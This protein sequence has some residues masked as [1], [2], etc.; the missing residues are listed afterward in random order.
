MESDLRKIPSVDRLLHNP[1]IERRFAGY[2]H[3]MLVDALRWALQHVREHI[4][5]GSEFSLD[6][7]LKLVAARVSELQSRSLI[8]VINATGVVLHTNL[9]RAPLATQAMESIA[10]VGVGYNNLEISLETGL[11]G[12]RVVH[13]RDLLCDLT[14]AEEAL[15]VNNNAAAVLLAL[16]TL[17]RGKEVIVSRG[18]LIEIGGS[19]RLPD[20]L[21]RSGA[22]LVEVGTTNRTYLR[23]YEAAVTDETALFLKSHTS[24]YRITGFSFRPDVKDLVELGQKCSV[25]VMEDLGSGLM[26]DLSPWGLPEEPVIRQVVESGV[27]LVSFSGDKLL[28][29]PQAGIVVGRTELVSKMAA[30]PLARALRV[31]KLTL[32]ALEP[33]LRVYRWSEHPEQEI[34]HLRMMV[35]PIQSVRRRANRLARRLR[36]L[37]GLPYEVSV[38]SEMA[39]VG[40]GSLPGAQIPTVALA[41]RSDTMSMDQLA[42]WLRN[43]SPPILGRIVEDR[44]IL[45][46][47]T[48]RNEE[49]GLI[50]ESIHQR[51]G[52]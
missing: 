44:V 51:L 47:R 45:D 30:N 13:V 17:A 31:D 9:G 3:P 34:P 19:F 11:R 35:E 50:V 12:K 23:D 22:R 39:E 16:D 43:C 18:E 28:G 37:S 21:R 38:V 36:R 27:D 1:E 24:N 7:L 15:V 6:E 41:L 49:V 48:V 33:I 26:I 4:H 32:A 8:R 20:V 46:M 40:G 29:G 14:G 52:L 2:P 10:E 42:A 5:A 25:P